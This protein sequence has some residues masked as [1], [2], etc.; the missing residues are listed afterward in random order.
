MFV[1]VLTILAIGLRDLA[2]LRARLQ[3]EKS[4]NKALAGEVAAGI[5]AQMDEW[6]GTYTEWL[7]GR[8][9]LSIRNALC[10]QELSVRA[11]NRRVFLRHGTDWEPDSFSTALDP[12]KGDVVAHARRAALSKQWIEV[13]GEA[14]PGDG[15]DPLRY[16]VRM[17]GGVFDDYARRY[18]GE[19][20]PPSSRPGWGLGSVLVKDARLEWRSEFDAVLRVQGL[21]ALRVRLHRPVPQGA[22][23]RTSRRLV[24]SRRGCRGA[25]PTRYEVR[26]GVDAPERETREPTTERGWDPGGR[27]SLTS[28]RDE[29]IEVETRDRRETKRLRRA[30]ARCTRGSRG[31]RKA[32]GD[33]RPLRGVSQASSRIKRRDEIPDRNAVLIVFR[34]NSVRTDR[35]RVD[36]HR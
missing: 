32:L 13:R 9:V 26:L 3:R 12:P 34:R 30:V 18:Q 24:R 21:P 20:P 29:T 4:R 5:E 33:T 31:Y 11:D 25:A 7:T 16:G 28:D 8:G 17:T 35:I 19:T 22:R 14:E 27:R 15:F 1:A 6:K 36:S 2:D 10:E 23:P